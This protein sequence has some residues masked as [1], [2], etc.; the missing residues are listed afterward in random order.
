MPLPALA[1]V[2]T[3]PQGYRTLLASFVRALRAENAAEP[4]IRTYS[5]AIRLLAAFLV[6][7]GMPA[8][9]TT[10]SRE[11]IE[12]FITHLLTTRSPATAHSRFRALRRFFGWLESESEI[13]HSPM[14]RMKAPRLPE[15]PPEFLGED[16]LRRL[17][18]TCDGKTFIDRRDRAIIM[19]FIDTGLRRRELGT[20][21]LEDVDLDA[22]VVRVVGKGNRTRFVPFG[23][24]VAR[25]LDWYLRA[26]AQHRDASRP[27]F[28]LSH[29][30]AMTPSGVYQTIVKRAK[31][32]G[33][34]GVHPHLFRHG[35]ADAWLKA[36]GSEGDLMMIAG[37][38]SRGMLNRYGAAR[39]AD[40]ARAAHRRLSPG[41]RL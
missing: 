31:E 15:K 6:E 29:H 12:E 39:A 19:L 13:T 32:A 9:P 38:R 2:E 14:E 30:G 10:T 4:T 3:L 7:R 18:K 27:A 41:D 34:E 22:G 33:L 35:F 20:L 36:D 28:W 16:E 25:D 21:T 23:R 26:R 1:S 5:E 37:W 8:D 40:R 17:L 24:R 11:H